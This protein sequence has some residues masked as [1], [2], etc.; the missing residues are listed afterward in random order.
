[1]LGS[2]GL[3]GLALPQLHLCSSPAQLEP[4][5]PVP[6]GPA[7]TAPP[8]STMWLTLLSQRGRR[9]SGARCMDGSP[10]GYYFRRS[11]NSSADWLLF[12]E[13]GGWA[14]SP[15]DAVFRRETALGSSK[16]WPPSR[17]GTG[18]LSADP[19]VNPDLGHLN[20]AY[21]KYCDGFCFAGGNS[22]P[23]VHNGSA[24]IWFSGKANLDAIVEDLAASRGLKSAERVLLGGSSAGALAVYLHVDYLGK[25]LRQLAP[26]L[27]EYRGV[28]D[29]GWF[30]DIKNITG[31]PVWH[32]TH[33]H[34][35][36]ASVIPPIHTSRVLAY[37]RACGR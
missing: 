15:S 23:L 22:T 36:P 30:P 18:I 17:V 32:H 5:R 14:F 24:P 35:L 19:A 8:N 21:L 4:P 33:A 29:A 7:A 37:R 9:P 3:L 34:L 31:K 13:G 27:V 28:A 1:M 26:R 10:P 16:T 25:R 20:V 6:R 11:S 2:L 12:F